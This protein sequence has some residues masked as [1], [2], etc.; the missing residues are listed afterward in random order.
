VP[1]WDR[2]KESLFR[3]LR[4]SAPRAP[5]MGVYRGVVVSQSGQ[6]V[7]TKPTDQRLPGMSG[8]PIQV[9]L[10]GATVEV[11]PG[12]RMLIGFEDGDPARPIA[13]LWDQGA[14]ARR[15]SLPTDLLELGGEGV[16]DWVVKGSTYRSAEAALHTSLQTT[17]AAAAAG[18][19]AAGAAGTHSA[20][21][22]S[23]IAAGAALTA[24]VAAITAFE[25]QAQMYLSTT[26]RTA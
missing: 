13:L 2:V 17:L 8:L 20:A 9:G 23:F 26:V 16:A 10:P 21:Q 19:A 12:A 25:A 1:A 7:D 6:A 4:A 5:Y 3:L 22:P 15:I 24:A 18:L 14:Q 11:S